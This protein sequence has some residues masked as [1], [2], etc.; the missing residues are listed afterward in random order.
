MRWIHQMLQSSQMPV[1]AGQAFL[2]GG[3]LLLQLG[4][5]RF[6]GPDSFGR[7]A[8]LILYAYLLISICNALIIQPLQVSYAAVSNKPAYLG[9]ALCM[10]S[11]AVLLCILPSAFLFLYFP[12][13]IGGTEGFPLSGL[14]YIAAFLFQDFFRK[15]FLAQSRS[16]VALVCDI[17]SAL[18]PL[19]ALAFLVLADIRE[20]RYCLFI[21]SVSLAP[22]FLFGILYLGFQITWPSGWGSYFT[23]HFRQGFWLILSAVVQWA[24][25]HILIISSGLWLGAA[26][27]GAFRLVQ[28]LFGVLNIVLQT[29]ENYVLPRASALCIESPGRAIDYLRGVSVRYALPF[30]AV[31]AALFASS[32]RVIGWAGGSAYEGYGYVVKGMSLLYGLIL[33]SYPLRILIRIQLMNRSFFAGYVA[34]FL[35][36]LVFCRY[37]LSH[38]GLSGMLAGLMANQLLMMGIWTY[39]LTTNKEL[40]WK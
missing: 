1:L 5:A 36:S 11:V 3:G 12:A 25:S 38:W 4:L 14:L 10:Q 8:L 21:L 20:L 15:V 29:F 13:F 35:F 17:L 34:A 28:S 23:L 6:L 40:G 33:L 32:G 37:L 7:Y 16:G 19:L 22:S 2:S 26:A 30:G 27:L 24:S 31:L 9:F 39:S 18:G